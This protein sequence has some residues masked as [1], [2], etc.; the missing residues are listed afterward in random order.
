MSD[1]QS[2]AITEFGLAVSKRLSQAEFRKSGS[3]YSS[4]N[5]DFSGNAKAGDVIKSTQYTILKSVIR[6]SVLSKQ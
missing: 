6:V 3:F 5:W 2:K 1:Q 4:W